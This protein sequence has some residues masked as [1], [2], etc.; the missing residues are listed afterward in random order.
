M[1]LIRKIDHL[2][3][4]SLHNNR[5]FTYDVHL[6]EEEKPHPVIIFCHGFKGFKDWGQFDLIATAFAS[7]G[8]TTFKV[9]FSHNGTSPQH[10]IDFVD[11]EAFGQNNFSI[12]LD[13]L[14]VLLEKITESPESAYTKYINPD[15][16]FLL[17]HSKGGST[18]IIK[19]CEDDRI[20][21]LA[22]WAAVCHITQRYSADELG[23]WKK[24]GVQYI[25]NGRTEQNMPLYYQLAE[26]VLNNFDRFDL[27]NIV[28]SLQKPYL[29]IH[30]TDD[31][32]VIPEEGKSLK[33][34]CNSAELCLIEDANHTFGGTHPYN[35][36]ELPIYTKKAVERTTAF[37][38]KCML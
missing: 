33:A 14:D 23:E 29:I 20:K 1:T 12:E 11:L 9:N 27:P 25:Y 36:P 21:G 34:N 38:L 10:P 22:T 3:L 8:F 17:G 31:T 18:S 6:P 13:D 5:E 15:E 26:D 28:Q 4:T 24:N 32:S 37:F 30:G 19:T 35:E 2:K 16:I 7:A